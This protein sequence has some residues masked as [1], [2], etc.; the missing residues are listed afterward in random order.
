MADE[1]LPTFSAITG[2][3][4]PS[5]PAEKVAEQERHRTCRDERLLIGHAEPADV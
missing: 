2:C 5:L 1:K 4:I 3:D